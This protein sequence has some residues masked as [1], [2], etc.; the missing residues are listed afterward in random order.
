MAIGAREGFR[1]LGVHPGNN[2]KKHL[3]IISSEELRYQKDSTLPSFSVF[4]THTHTLFPRFSFC[5]L[6]AFQRTKNY[7][8]IY[9]FSFLLIILVVLT[10]F[11]AFVEGFKKA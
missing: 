7:D 5:L 9:S 1:P 4:H 11:V 2:N 3:L 6:V 10:I 8:A